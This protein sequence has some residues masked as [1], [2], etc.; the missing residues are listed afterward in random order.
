MFKPK[1]EA[2]I[3]YAMMEKSIWNHCD[4]KSQLE[5]VWNILSEIIDD[6]KDIDSRTQTKAILLKI[7]F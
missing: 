2:T 4:P 6:T 5:A 3:K 1:F 7:Y